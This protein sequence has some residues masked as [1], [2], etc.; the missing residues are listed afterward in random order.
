MK[1]TSEDMHAF[2]KKEFR[3]ELT[4]SQEDCNVTG[5]GDESHSVDDS[6]RK[7]IPDSLAF[8]RSPQ[9]TPDTERKC[10]PSHRHKSGVTST[11]T[12]RHA[13][14]AE[15][16]KLKTSASAYF[17][18]PLDFE[19]IVYTESASERDET[20]QDDGSAALD[21]R[22]V[23]PGPFLVKREDDGLRK[24][25][26]SIFNKRKGLKFENLF[27]SAK[28]SREITATLISFLPLPDLIRLRQLTKKVRIKWIA[29]MLRRQRRGLAL[30]GFS[31]LFRML[32]W[33]YTLS[34]WR[35]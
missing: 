9:K 17:S 24:L 28:A 33:N 31:T 20:Q 7:L 30:R 15:D 1:A 14:E 11:R 32:H 10:K 2:L 8:R 23:S 18:P 6:E 34:L 3:Q 35:M 27:F 25:R 16:V 19:D 26:I 5:S 29:R 12:S 22:T 4:Y 13:A 21:I